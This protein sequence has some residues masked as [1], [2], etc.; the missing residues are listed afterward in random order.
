ML[1]RIIKSNHLT[2]DPM[3]GRNAPDIESPK[4]QLGMDLFFSKT[5]GGDSDSACVTCHHPALGGGR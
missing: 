1:E 3:L 4:A 2:G 5:L